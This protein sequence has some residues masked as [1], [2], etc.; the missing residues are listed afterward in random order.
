MTKA[1]ASLSAAID[2]RNVETICMA[3]QELRHA[4]AK[5]PLRTLY[6]ALDERLGP[7]AIS[8]VV[9]AHANRHCF[10]CEGGMVP[11][12]QC[13]GHGECRDDAPGGQCPY[14]DGVGVVPCGFC[15]GDGWADGSVTPPEL[16]R[17]ARESQLKRVQ[18]ETTR[19]HQQ[20]ASMNGDDLTKLPAGIR[21]QVAIWAMKLAARLRTLEE[22]HQIPPAD[23]QAHDTAV[24]HTQKLLGRLCGRKHAV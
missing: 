20:M 16:R 13:E 8:A 4:A 22:R 24:H 11:C 21:R 15:R 18:E 7:A 14:C 5:M 23:K 12:D 1:I 10:M 9:A 2:S 19:L 6:G 3:Y 17:A